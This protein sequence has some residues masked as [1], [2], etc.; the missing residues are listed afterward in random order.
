[1]T[2][3]KIENTALLIAHLGNPSQCPRASR[4]ISHARKKGLQ[5]V[6]LCEGSST[7]HASISRSSKNIFRLGNAILLTFGFF[8]FY[9]KLKF[10]LKHAPGPEITSVI[11][12][13]IL[14]L[15]LIRQAYPSAHLV[16]DAREY[17]PREFEHSLIW[18]LS[19]GRLVDWICRNYLKKVDAAY[20]VS[21]GIAREYKRVYGCEM[22]VAY[23]FPDEARLSVG[24]VKS[25]VRLVYHGNASRDRCIEKMIDAVE[26]LEYQ[27]T[28]DL[29]LVTVDPK[30][31]GFLRRMAQDV[32]N[33]RIIEPVD[34]LR[35]VDVLNTYD[36]GL[37]VPPPSTFNL[38]FSLPN[39]LFE[40]IQARLM[41]VV[42]PL[43]EVSKFVRENNVGLIVP[44]FSASALREL[45]ENL[46]SSEIESFKEKSHVV[47]PEFVSE[48]FVEKILREFPSLP[49]L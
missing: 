20:T 36:V 32:S 18:R 15:P 10:K 48:K 11:V 9:L 16:L 6:R 37:F 8:S 26:G 45:L 14:I 35:I 19:S 40:Y 31:H 29:Y 23:S 42:T 33:V 17:F 22:E 27:A 21:K 7:G 4:L 30:Y 28:L 41:I 12:H 34:Q 3:Q 5:V 1:M 2:K 38:Q 49:A 46:S 13:D 43:S 44:D 25:P 39:K 24:P 47:A